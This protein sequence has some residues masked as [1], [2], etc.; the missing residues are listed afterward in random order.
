MRDKLPNIPNYII[1]HVLSDSGGS[2]IV[3]WGVDRRSGYPVAIKKPR[4][5]D[6]DALIRLRMEATHQLYLSQSNNPNMTR[7][8]DYVEKNGE[9]YLVMEYVEGTP[10][11]VYMKKLGK[12]MPDDFAIPV[13]LQML[14][15]VDYVHQCG[16][17]HKDIKPGNFILRNDMIVKLLDMGVST[18]MNYKDPM[19]SGTPSF[20]PPEQF[21]NGTTGRY[22][23]IFALG[24][25]LFYM[26]T[27]KMPFVG[28]GY[29]EIWQDIK[30]GR[31]PNAHHANPSLHPIYQTLLEKALN[32][33]CR[34]RYQSCSEFS[35]AVQQ[36]FAIARG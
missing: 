21:E 19:V 8:L 2:A 31:M 12:P 34:M 36:A 33:N 27:N 17:L 23:D 14:D 30:S 32:I 6:K 26:L 18:R 25:S 1:D 35:R 15:A 9:G 13:F 4:L 11:D 3:Y 28:N 20:M 7:L 24:V 16:Y 10:L 5:N 22:T 29:M